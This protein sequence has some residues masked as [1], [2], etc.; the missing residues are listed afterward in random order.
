M[1][2]KLLIK[3]LQTIGLGLLLINTAAAVDVALDEITMQ[4]IDVESADES[5]NAVGLP[6]E[7][8]QL[9]ENAE[10][11]KQDHLSGQH[12]DNDQFEN[13]TEQKDDE[14]DELMS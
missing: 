7:L 5:V 6:S 8:Q 9:I 14:K 11:D 10:L 4:L 1:K 3:C 13:K 2:S 12:A